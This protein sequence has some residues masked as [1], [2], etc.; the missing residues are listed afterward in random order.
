MIKNGRK[1]ARLE[2]RI[3]PAVLELVQHAAAM[4]GRSVSDFVVAAAQHAAEETIERRDIIALSRKDQERFA[5][6]MLRPARPSAA[7]KLPGAFGA[8]SLEEAC[9]RAGFNI[10][11]EGN[12]VS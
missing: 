9:M 10:C 1:T 7:V 11:F 2:T 6:A 12:P 8:Q 5:A 3:P 4:E